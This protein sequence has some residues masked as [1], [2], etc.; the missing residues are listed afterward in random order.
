MAA[1]LVDANYF[2]SDQMTIYVT[3][4]LIKKFAAA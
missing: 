3:F 2:F 4:E 1:G